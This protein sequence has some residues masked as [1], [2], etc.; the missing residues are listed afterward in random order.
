MKKV[1]VMDHKTSETVKEIVQA[2][3]DKK[4]FN[5]IALDVQG[6]ST[7]TDYFI[8]A[9]GN[10]DRHVKALANTVVKLQ[11]EKETIPLHVEGD[12]KGEW[13]VV[14]YGDI[15]IHLFTPGLRDKY[16]IESLWSAGNIIDVDIDM[17]KEKGEL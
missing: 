6:V 16:S 8:V 11:K 5:I 15:I 12:S 9:E 3:F 1:R 10:S 17:S 14:D 7:V 2:I 13:V 4:G